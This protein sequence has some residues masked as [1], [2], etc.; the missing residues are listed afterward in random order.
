[1][2]PLYL[3]IAASVLYAISLLARLM[4]LSSTQN[5]SPHTVAGS[6]IWPALLTHLLALWTVTN[7][8]TAFHLTV[9][10]AASL[11]FLVIVAIVELGRRR[12][13]IGNLLLFLLPLTILAVISML[14]VDQ[15][16]SDRQPLPAGVGLHVLLSIFAYSLLAIAAVQA[17]ALALLNRELKHRHTHGLI[18]MMPPLQ[19]MEQLLFQLLWCGELLLGL[20][21]LSGFVFLEDMF[22]QHL[23]HK[24]LL[25]ISG[26]VIFAVLLWGRHQ[27]GWRGKTAIRWTLSGFCVLLLAYFG[28]KVVLELIL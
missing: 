25:A 22:A 28:S 18:D 4:S 11:L 17:L 26:W 27:L 13:P 6:L 10:S 1:M 16:V 8:G 7:S 5:S 2:N 12:W 21:I 19:T 23:A 24:T 9:F 20:A 3:G 14:L 15:D